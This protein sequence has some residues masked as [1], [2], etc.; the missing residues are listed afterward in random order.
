MGS[1][2]MKLMQIHRGLILVAIVA[3]VT[4]SFVLGSLRAA[5]AGLA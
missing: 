3:T 2:V 1:P 4:G 5:G